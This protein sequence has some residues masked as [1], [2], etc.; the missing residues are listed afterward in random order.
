MRRRHQQLL[1]QIK[2]VQTQLNALPEGSLVCT[3]N[4]NY[5]KWYHSND[6]KLSYI[7]K[8][9]RF[10][11]E[12]LAAKKY[13]SH[14]LNELF[15]E[16]KAINTYLSLF[17]NQHGIQT[18]ECFPFI[19]ESDK[20]LTQDSGYRE[21]LVPYFAPSSQQLTQWLNASYERNPKYPEQLT[22]KAPSGNMVRSKSEAMIDMYLFTHHIPFR[23]ECALTLGEITLFPDF[24]IFHPDTRKLYYWEHFGRM[25]D[26]N[27][28][29]NV[30]SKLQ[31]YNSYGITPGIQL[32]TTY[33]TAD[34]PLS[35][36][37]IESIVAQYFPES[38]F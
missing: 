1:T 23:Y 4:G 7:P 2:Q 28:S 13:L 26:S 11:A 38:L 15:Q 8:K 27:Y 18:L 5:Y 24:T 37:T 25:D 20:M 32:I 21:L 16:E 35:F 12:Q 29:K 19:K 36:E 30:F 34:N 6:H 9:K 17:P 22:H 31:L 3:K 14:I 33:E 10:L